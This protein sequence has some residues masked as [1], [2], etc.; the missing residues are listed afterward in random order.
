M[1]IYIFFFKILF[2]YKL[3]QNI[4]YSSLCY[5]VGLADHLFYVCVYVNPSLLIY[6]SRAPSWVFLRVRS[7]E[8]LYQECWMAS[9][10][11]SSR[12]LGRSFRHRVHPA[13]PCQRKVA[14]LASQSSWKGGSVSEAPTM[15]SRHTLG[16]IPPDPGRE[17]RTLRACGGQP[18]G[19]PA[20]G[21]A[22][23]ACW[24]WFSWQAQ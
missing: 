9:R 3:L 12:K 13:F 11:L 8:Q 7:H 20:S 14:G 6:S 4:E 17:L 2:P 21:A 15:Q 1:C 19:V 23:G 10:I 16:L 24:R 18:L 5:I 22:V